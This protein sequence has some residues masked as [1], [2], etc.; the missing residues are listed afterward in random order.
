M[1]LPVAI[2]LGQPL[3]DPDLVSIASRMCC[4]RGR[5][6]WP[7]GGAG[8]RRT[9][10]GGETAVTLTWLDW[11]KGWLASGTRREKQ[12]EASRYEKS[13]N[14]ERENKNKTLTEEVL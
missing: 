9:T 2:R 1:T 8:D 5:R 14:Q 12:T 11:T 6:V 4:N 10:A 3:L 7:N 13:R